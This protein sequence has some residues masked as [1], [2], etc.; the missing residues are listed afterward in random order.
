M[1]IPNAISILRLALIVP[2]A[3]CL[4]GHLYVCAAVLYAAAS[5]TDALD[6][7]MA[8]VLGQKTLLGSFL[9]P[10]GDKALVAVSFFLLARLGHIAWWVFWIALGRDA[11]IVAGWCVYSLFTNEKQVVPMVI[12]KI[13][14]I[15]QMTFLMIFLIVLAYGAGEDFKARYIYPMVIGVSVMAVISVIG[16]YARGVGLIWRKRRE[17]RNV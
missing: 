11:L 1:N 5:I 8:R 15:A 3:A 2:F 7:Y 14:T 17:I 9:D 6:G 10:L 12:G 16:Y 13:T 4:S